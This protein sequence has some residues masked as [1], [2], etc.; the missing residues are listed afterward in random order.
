MR[1]KTKQ[2]ESPESATHPARRGSGS[3]RMRWRLLVSVALAAGAPV[4]ATAQDARRPADA[5]ARLVDAPAL[6]SEVLRAALEGN[7]DIVD[8]ALEVEVAREQVSE[9]RSGL[10][11]TIDLSSSFTRN[12]KPPISFLPAEFFGGEPGEYIQV[13]FGADNNWQL[14]IDAEQPLLD[15]RA[16]IGLGAADGLV[17]IS[18]E[19]A[20][21]RTQ[22]AVTRVRIA[23]Y[24]L[25][26]AR[27]E[28]RLIERSLA[29]V[30]QVLSDTR[31]MQG[32]GLASEYDVLRLEVE[33]ASLEPDLRRARNRHR[34]ARRTLAVDLGLEPGAEIEAAGSLAEID[35]DDVEANSAGNRDIL[36]LQGVAA[37]DEAGTRSLMERGVRGRA[38]VRQLAVSERLR[39]A[40]LR[41][42][43]VEYLP[44]V[45]AFGS[46]GLSAQHDGAPKFFGSSQ[47]RTESRL[48]GLRV[49][50]PLFSGLSRDARI[51]QRRATLRRIRS[52]SQ[53]AVDRAQAELLDLLGQVQEARS[54]ASAQ[55]LAVAQAS[56]GFEIAAARYREGTGSRFEQTDAEVAL[57]RSEFNYARAVYDYLSARARL[58][59]ASGRVPFVD[60]GAAGVPLG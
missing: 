18:R 19:A 11:P 51:D 14:S 44:K 38:D 52:Q 7:P 10:Y 12:V 24:D 6:L 32:A 45:Y 4:A 2:A 30:Q 28:V 35:L 57:R 5:G 17:Q 60:V 41:L 31:A 21:G 15:M 39:L 54:R 9:A 29:R 33:V 40:E 48:V 26:L 50:I 56:R 1:L 22:D 59:L 23:F 46:Y 36:A 16:V 34:S 13:R 27:E 42:E 53:A 43:Q 47:E 20:R 3:R 49:T 58:D 8:A 25:L 37:T 55:H